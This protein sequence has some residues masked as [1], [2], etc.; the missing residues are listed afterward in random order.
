MCRSTGSRLSSASTATSSPNLQPG[1]DAG[2]LAS[3]HLQANSHGASGTANGPERNGSKSVSWE[4]GRGRNPPYE[5]SLRG[6]RPR[7][8]PHPSTFPT[9]NESRCA[10]TSPND[11]L[12]RR[13]RAELATNDPDAYA[14][15][16]LV[17]LVMLLIFWVPWKRILFLLAVVAVAFCVLAELSMGFRFPFN[18]LP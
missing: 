8:G 16:I 17:S 1:S 14:P 3:V 7:L 10:M 6:T 9:H 4:C 12:Y 18:L 5:P 15:P 11:S 2:K 13:I